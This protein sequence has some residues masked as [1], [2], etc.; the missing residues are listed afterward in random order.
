MNFILIYKVLKGKKMPYFCDFPG[1]H[2]VKPKRASYGYIDKIPTR[3]TK[4]NTFEM[5]D[6]VSP[7][8]N[9]PDHIG[10]KQGKAR[11]GMKNEKRIRCFYHKEDNMINLDA[12]YCD[13]IEHLNS[14][15]VYASYGFKTD[16]RPSKC[17]KHANKEMIHLNGIFCNDPEHGDD[18]PVHATYGNKTGKKIKCAKHADTNMIRSNVYNC[19]HPSHDIN[20]PVRARYGPKNGKPI[21]CGKHAEDKMICL[22]TILC[23]DLSHGDDVVHASFGFKN[24]KKIKCGKH[25]EIGMIN[26]RGIFCNDS[27]HTIDK[28]VQASF[29]LPKGKKTKCAKHAEDNMIDLINKSCIEKDCPIKN[30]KFGL[31]FQKK[32]HCATH[33]TKNEYKKNNPKCENNKCKGDKKRPFYTNDGTNYPKRCED[34]KIEGDINIVEKPCSSCKLPNFIIDNS[35][36]CNDCRD[37]SNI[38]IRKAK[39]NYIGEVLKNN[40]YEIESHDKPI[41]LLCSQ[42]RPDFVIKYYDTFYVIVEVDEKQHET[43]PQTCER[44]RM[45]QI[46]NDLGGGPVFFIR[47]N[48]DNYIDHLGNKQIGNEK[49]LLDLLN[50]L[51]NIDFEELK[52]TLSVYYVCYDGFDGTFNKQD[53]DA[54]KLFKELYELFLQE[55]SE[56]IN[57]LIKETKIMLTNIEKIKKLLL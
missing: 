27:S 29:G 37:F 21:K 25:A 56:K 28:P 12:I 39:E 13:N 46:F 11:F 18:N 6:L 41:D 51:K 31:L 17:K 44:K 33:K 32:I 16:K 45:V 15:S 36:L 22:H 24:D 48:P 20:N 34:C 52:P 49:Y 54:D 8:C 43:Y 40:K 55:I 2:P 26:L 35:T 38:K 47:Y 42:Y 50:R 30:A 7:K 10:N 5:I 9:H 1:G 23:N 3:C 4:H 19:N 14:K 57:F 53:I